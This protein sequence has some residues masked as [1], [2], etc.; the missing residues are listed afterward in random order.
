MG[1]IADEPRLMPHL[2]LSLQAGDDLILKRMKR[3]HMRADVV[4]LAR[5]CA[6]CGPDIVFGADLIAGFPTENEAM[7]R[8]TL[9][10]GRGG[11]LTFLHVFPYS[12][13]PARRRRACR[14]C[15]RA[16]ARSA[17]RGCG[18]G[19][20]ALE[21]FL[22]GQLGPAARGCWSS[23]AA[24]G[25]PSSSRRSGFAEARRC[26]RPVGPSPSW[27]ST[28]VAERAC[29]GARRLIE[30][31]GAG[32]RGSRR[33]C[34]APRAASPRRSR[35]VV[36]KR[37]LDEAT[38][39]ELEEALITADLGVETAAVLVEGLAK[40]RFGKEVT[41]AEVREALAAAIAK[42]L[43]PVAEPLPHRAR[44]RPQVVLVCGVNGTG[45][46]TTIGK[47]ANRP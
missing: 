33:A 11:G 16:C 34:R 18:R 43:E 21:R 6:G 35:S 20:G 12:P 25:T 24:A 29:S 27:R 8:D 30:G 39:D 38:L 42:D 22:R 41:D 17:R 7:F 45:K 2:H 4:R 19:G 9:R 10:P 5:G 40:D 15:R 32:S 1:L 14:R 26:R 28:G 47:L 44:F 13:G 23:A 36:T 31:R 3:R 37:R 46:T